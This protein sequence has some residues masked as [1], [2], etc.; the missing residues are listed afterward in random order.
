M[1]YQLDTD[2]IIYH[3]RGKKKLE[4]EWLKNKPAISVITLGKLLYG[5]K[6]SNQQKENV[7][8]IKNFIKK[9]DIEVIPIDSEVVETYS[10]IK[11]LLEKQGNNLD[12]FDLLIGSTAK[13]KNLTLVT[14][15][16]KHF[17]K[18]LDLK[19]L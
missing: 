13:N 11:I 6:K 5:T 17:E 8:K 7:L 12:D 2:V 18:I 9:F 16:K 19:I 4:V 1:R 15:N 10:E 14:N 3:F